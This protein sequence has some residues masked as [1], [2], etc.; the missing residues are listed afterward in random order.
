MPQKRSID[1]LLRAARLYYI[2]GRCQ[3][4][5]AERLQLSP[6]AVSRIILAAR[7]QGIVEFRIETDPGRELTSREWPG[8]T[9]R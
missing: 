2:E 7:E 8:R 4:E 6:S 1:L 3:R 5:V 9:G